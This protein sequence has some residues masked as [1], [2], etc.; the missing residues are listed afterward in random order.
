LRPAEPPRIAAVAPGPPFDP[1]TWSGSSVHLLRALEAAGAL[2]G[3]VDGG[4]RALDRIEQLAS[5]SHS[6]ARWRQRYH[7]RSSP[8]SAAARAAR[9]R[10]ANRRLAS[11][12]KDGDALL[13]IGAWHDVTRLGTGRLCC[14]YHD[15]NL[16]VS[17]AREELALDRRSRS[18]RRALEAERRLYDRLDLILPMSDW[19]RRSFVDDFGQD[20]EKVVTVGAGPNLSAIPPEPQRSFERPVFLFVGKQWERKGGP[21]V[22]DAF[23]LLRAER[24]DAE[25]VIVGP[26]SLPREVPGVRFLGRISRRSPDGEAR[27]DEAYRRA[28]AF[29]MP[30]RYEPFGIVFL[31][32]MAYRLPCIAST[33]CAMPEIVA[34]GETGYV[35]AAGD[36]EALAA[37]MLSLAEP[38]RARELGA[39]GYRRLLERF[40]WERVAGKIVAAVGERLP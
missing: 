17:L 23:E 37:R 32:A 19:L 30:S 39:A 15:G 11:L 18:V 38:G 24:P 4:S 16:A 8:L 12:A 35:V 29:V 26:E 36:P 1:E 6:R 20:P 10:I 9:G 27:L 3:A 2:A 28:T 14:S 33:R 21:D 31:E 40:T 34:E 25:L 13:Q 22:L 7:T 5:F